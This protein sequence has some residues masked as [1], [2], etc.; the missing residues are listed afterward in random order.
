[1]K[2]VFVAVGGSG[3]KVAEALVRLLA[4]GF[5]TRRDGS[6]YTSAGDS[7]QIWR[8]DPDRSSGA[9]VALQQCIKEYVELQKYLGDGALA[10]NAFGSP[11]SAR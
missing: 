6:T 5:P 9:A 1:M 2:N 11:L 10:V 4:V 7:L 8:V 3:A